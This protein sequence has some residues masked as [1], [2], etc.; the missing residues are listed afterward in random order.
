MGPLLNPVQGSLWMTVFLHLKEFI[1]LI[2][3]CELHESAAGLLFPTFP[4]RETGRHNLLYQ[5]FFYRH[6]SVPEHSGEGNVPFTQPPLEA[7]TNL[8]KESNL[9]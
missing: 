3:K 7:I 8:K 2:S 1:L 9:L 4:V 5:F 6:H